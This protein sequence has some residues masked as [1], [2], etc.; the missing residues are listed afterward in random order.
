M[1]AFLV[2]GRATSGWAPAAGFRQVGPGRSRVRVGPLENAMSAVAV[3]TGGSHP[4][5]SLHHAVV[6]TL[7][8]LVD[9]TVLGGRSGTGKR[10]DEFHPRQSKAHRGWHDS[11]R[12]S[13]AWHHR[14]RRWI[15]P[16]PAHG[17]PC[18]TGCIHLRVQAACQFIHHVFMTHGARNRTEI[19][20]VV[21]KVFIGPF[22][23]VNTTQI[24]MNRYGKCL[25]LIDGSPSAP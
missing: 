24:P 2:K 18:G 9:D 19:V 13:S 12:T 15:F 4:V 23:A 5:R 20:R 1:D 17:S 16:G 25:M 22:M 14:C 8:I 11:G 10:P 21:I 3:R 7:P 6:G